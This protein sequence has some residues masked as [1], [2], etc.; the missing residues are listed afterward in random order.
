MPRSIAVVVILLSGAVRGFFVPRQ[1]P[2][3]SLVLQAKGFGTKDTPAPKKKP[4]APVSSQSPSPPPP[5]EKNIDPFPTQTSDQNDGAR[6]LEKM[7]RERAE[8]R[9]QELLKVKEVQDVDAMLR[10]SPAAAVI[11]E[12]VAQRMGKRMLPFVGI[13]LFGAMGSFVGFWYMASY[14]DTEFEPALVASVSIAL[15]VVGLLVRVSESRS[16]WVN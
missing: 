5:V 11:P 2:S 12:R 15:L 9:N 1:N 8:K 6:A 3:R 13:P 10:E 7:R 14:R 4:T 16:R